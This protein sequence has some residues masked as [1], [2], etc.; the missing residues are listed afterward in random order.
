M[1]DK[2][3][4]KKVSC[5]IA[6]PTLIG[7]ENVVLSA[8]EVNLFNYTGRLIGQPDGLFRDGFGRWHIMEYKCGGN[9][10]EKAVEQLMRSQ[11]HLFI[12]GIEKDSGLIYVHGDYETVK[13]K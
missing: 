6:T 1:S 3:H 4:D 9:K 8:K 2:R 5:I 13:I 12:Y 7:L 11:E 10:E